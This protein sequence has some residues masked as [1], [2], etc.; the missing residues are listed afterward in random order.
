MVDRE[1][2]N[3]GNYSAIENVCRAQKKWVD[4][5][6]TGRLFTLTAE[7]GERNNVNGKSVRAE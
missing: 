2:R 6:G 4:E 1:G 5:G 3:K 7:R